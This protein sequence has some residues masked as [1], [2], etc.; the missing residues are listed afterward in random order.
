MHQSSLSS[1]K[2]VTLMDVM[3]PSHQ[4]ESAKPSLERSATVSIRLAS[5]LEDFSIM[6]VRRA[7]RSRSAVPSR[8][9]SNKESL[10]FSCQ[11]SSLLQSMNLLQSKIMF[12]SKHCKSQ[13]QPVFSINPQSSVKNPSPLRPRN[14]AKSFTDASLS[15][16]LSLA[17]KRRLRRKTW[18]SPEYPVYSVGSSPWADQPRV[19]AFVV[20]SICDGYC[21]LCLFGLH[22]SHQF[23]L[24]RWH[25]F[26]IPLKQ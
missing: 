3:P 13:L 17:Q 1:T 11:S 19:I 24:R 25:L 12:L 20:Y 18:Y 6:S 22:T 16:T 14:S 7:R 9:I 15:I 4:A 2:P 26:Q 8:L 10:S 23:S 21:H 5:N